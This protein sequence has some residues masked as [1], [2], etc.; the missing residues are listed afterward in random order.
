[1]TAAAVVQQLPSLAKAGRAN[2]A[3]TQPRRFGLDGIARGKAAA[4]AGAD[5]TAAAVKARR[6]SCGCRQNRQ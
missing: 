4:N 6:R 5:V 2:G 1:M 3:K